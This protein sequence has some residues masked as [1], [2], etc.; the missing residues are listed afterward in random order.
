MSLTT[1][2]A[3]KVILNFPT[4][5]ADVP[6]ENR[7]VEHRDGTYVH[8]IDFDGAGWWEDFAPRSNGFLFAVDHS[9]VTDE[10]VRDVAEKAR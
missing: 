2:E 8:I 1:E 10:A 4:D 9:L 7:R 5:L 3:N 6:A